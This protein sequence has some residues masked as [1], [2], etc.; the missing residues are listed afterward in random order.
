MI[1]NKILN[2]ACVESGA[3]ASFNYCQGVA[4]GLW[5]MIS[6][7]KKQKTKNAQKQEEKTPAGRKLAE[8]LQREKE[9]ERLKGPYEDMKVKSSPQTY[10]KDNNGNGILLP[11]NP[12]CVE[13]SNGSIENI[14]V[15]DDGI[16][17][18]DDN[19]N[20]K[21][22]DSKIELDF[23]LDSIELLEDAAKLD[24]EVEKVLR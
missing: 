4:D 23:K 8:N 13:S 18:H 21:G 3:S 2:W 7:Q 24:E 15:Y 20:N 19:D 17:G 22:L 12:I 16:K 5:Y 10:P 14:S 6:D 11:H 1:N 9:I